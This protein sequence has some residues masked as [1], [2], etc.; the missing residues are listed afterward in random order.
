[1]IC[2][3]MMCT[4]CMSKELHLIILSESSFYSQR[5]CITKSLIWWGTFHMIWM[6]NDDVTC[7]YV[8]LKLIL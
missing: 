5:G 4:R 6:T 7:L 2:Y 1:M 8:E 3:I